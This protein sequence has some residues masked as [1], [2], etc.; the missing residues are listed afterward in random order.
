M[1]FKLFIFLIGVL[2][3]GVHCTRN[4]EITPE[5]KKGVSIESSCFSQNKSFIGRYFSG[6]VNS[7]KAL[8]SFFDCMD[9]LVQALLNHTRTGHPDYY[10][11]VELSRFILY[12]GGAKTAQTEKQA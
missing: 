8:D 10:T 5:V 4:G 7:S 11:K 9:N 1:R 6:Q 3:S 2:L 12:M